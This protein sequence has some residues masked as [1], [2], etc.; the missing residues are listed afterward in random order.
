[1]KRGPSQRGELA[2]RSRSP[3]RKAVNRGRSCAR[4]TALATYSS[5]LAA[6]SSGR[7]TP[8]RWLTPM[9]LTKWSPARVTT[10]TPIQS[11]STVVVPP[12]NGNGSSATSIC[13]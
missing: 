12:L 6:I 5:L 9:R 2:I 11:A 13:R 10:G 4:P 7:P 3:A 8:L 1:M